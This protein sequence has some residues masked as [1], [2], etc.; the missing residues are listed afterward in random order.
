MF[1]VRS[2]ELSIC[3]PL[4]ELNACSYEDSHTRRGEVFDV[5]DVLP[6]KPTPFEHLELNIPQ[7]PEKCLNQLYGEDALT[8]V[9]GVP[10]ITWINNPKN[11]AILDRLF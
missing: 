5:M 4:D 9:R 8:Q 7:H 1:N 2:D 3:T 11:R 6:L 10:H